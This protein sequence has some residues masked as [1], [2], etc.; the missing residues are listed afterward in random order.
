[1]VFYDKPIQLTTPIT[2]S[3]VITA[4]E[5]SIDRIVLYQSAYISV[6][7]KDTN[8]AEIDRKQLIMEG[9][10]YLKWGADDDYI[11]EFVRTKIQE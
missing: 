10:D 9:D 2:K 8:S 1:M 4:F 5:I 6:I 7:L 11:I 3:T